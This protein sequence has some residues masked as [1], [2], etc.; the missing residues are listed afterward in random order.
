M[1][2]CCVPLLA[3]RGVNKQ[4]SGLAVLKHIDFTLIA[5]QVHAL[6]GGNGAGQST[7]MLDGRT[8]VI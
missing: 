2:N 1:F 7:L 6:L 8:S 3:V 4:F 5:G